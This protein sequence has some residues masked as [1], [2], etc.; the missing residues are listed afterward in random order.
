MGNKG[1]PAKR[2]APFSGRAVLT[3][4]RPGGEHG[5]KDGFKTGKCLR[6]DHSPAVKSLSG[7]FVDDALEGRVVMEFFD[8]SITVGFARRNRLIGAVRS[9]SSTDGLAKSVRM[10]MTT[11]RTGQVLYEQDRFGYLRILAREKGSSERP[12]TSSS[13]DSRIIFTKD[14]GEVLNCRPADSTF[15]DDCRVMDPA[16]VKV[17][18]CM[19]YLS[20]E[21]VDCRGGKEEEQE[22]EEPFLFYAP[23]S[24]RR[25]PSNL[26]EEGELCPEGED[27]KVEGEGKA[28]AAAAA[29]VRKDFEE[30]LRRVEANGTGEPFWSSHYD[31]SERP[32]DPDDPEVD[33]L[34]PLFEGRPGF[35]PRGVRIVSADRVLFSGE[36]SGGRIKGKVD[37]DSAR[38][39]DWRAPLRIELSDHP[40]VSGTAGLSI[41]A[42]GV[43]DLQGTGGDVV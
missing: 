24:E 28:A 35:E 36:M 10:N 39:P 18:Q 34:L 19:A 1:K 21:G 11:V 5:F 4:A 29:A 17:R 20:S 23:T 30:W 25:R 33:I 26:A 15:F 41:G 14:F 12:S 7:Q 8:D 31:P 6:P 37:A 42:Y 40:S 27:M 3:F 13:S 38:L 22:Q 16:Q 43:V 2:G 9:F 32:L